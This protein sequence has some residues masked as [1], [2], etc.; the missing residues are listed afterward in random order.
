MTQTIPRG[1][2]NGK[3]WTY[4]WIYAG[5]AGHKPQRKLQQGVLRLDPAM[6]RPKRMIRR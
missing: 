4:A 2:A 5:K 6:K 3:F 1:P